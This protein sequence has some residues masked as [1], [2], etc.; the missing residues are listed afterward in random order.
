MMHR[1]RPLTHARPKI[2]PYSTKVSKVWLRPISLAPGP[3]VTPDPSQQQPPEDEPER[4]RSSKENYSRGGGTGGGSSGATSSALSSALGTAAGILLLAGA[5][6]VYHW[7]YKWDVLRKMRRAFGEGYDPVTE[8]ANAARDSK[9]GPVIGKIRR[10]E[11]DYIDRIINGTESGEYVLLL[12]PKGSGKTTLIVEAMLRND[13][14]GCAMVEAHED[15]EV[16]R[17]RLGKAL[18]FEYS[19]DSFAGLFQRR[20]PREAGPSLD[21]ERAMNKLEKVA[22]KYRKEKGRPL[23]LIFNNIHYIHDDEDGHALL[24]MLQQRAESWSQAG[25]LTTIFTSDDFAPY[26]H[27]K[28]YASRMNVLNV[29]DLSPAETYAVLARQRAAR[30]PGDPPLDPSTALAV[31]NLVGGRLAY[32]S[33]IS[34]RPDMVAAAKEMI[35]KEKA[36][37]LSRLSLI[38]EH[39]DDVMDEQ[40]VSSCGFLL[41]H[42]FAKLADDAEEETKAALEQEANRLRLLPPVLGDDAPLDAYDLPNVPHENDHWIGYGDAKEIMTRADFIIDLDHHNIVTINADH[43]VRPD[44]RLMLNVF[45]E[46]CSQPDFE[47]RLATTRDRIDEIESLHRTSELTVKA[48]PADLGGF[49]RIKVGQLLKGDL[50][51]NEEGADGEEGPKR[52]V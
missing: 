31:W 22:I 33:K 20:D 47:E 28:K 43:E 45:R 51:S 11:Q 39:D 50:E 12:G 1:L 9:T 40:K 42:E 7:T 16:F 36:W 30:F 17:L 35:K 3:G 41:F 23:V 2:L 10:L 25:V 48:A 44:S 32:L 24:H 34:R 13:A 52:E 8:L 38:P 27:L 19:E 49:L 18:D 6:L 4:P 5:G 29:T 26:S 15:P 14:E 21:I 46:L 37:L